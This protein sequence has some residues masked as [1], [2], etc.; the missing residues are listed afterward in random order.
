MAFAVSQLFKTASFSQQSILTM[1]GH[2]DGVFSFGSTMQ[3]AA[4]EMI[5]YLA[6][7]LAIDPINNSG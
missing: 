3:Q 4:Q 6:F 1:L 5:K 2:A 7:A